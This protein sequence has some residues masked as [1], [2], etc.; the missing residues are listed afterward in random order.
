MVCLA[1]AEGRRKLSE[2]E[3]GGWR[4]PDARECAL[5]CC[6]RIRRFFTLLLLCEVAPKLR[7]DCLRTEERRRL[8]LVAS[9]SLRPLT[10]PLPEER[11]R[12]C[13]REETIF[14]YY[15]TNTHAAVK[16]DYATVKERE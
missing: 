8:V 7:S 5:F 11:R 15:Y 4:Q 1:G 16:I 2:E 10:D 6:C 12:M 3:R 13:S 9:R 14:H